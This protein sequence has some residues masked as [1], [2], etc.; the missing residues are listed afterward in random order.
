[1]YEDWVQV[2]ALVKARRLELDPLF[3]KRLALERFE[4]AFAALGKG[5]AGKILL[6]PNIV[7]G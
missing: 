5:A 1:M 3:G 7:L 2:T 4:E 6:Y